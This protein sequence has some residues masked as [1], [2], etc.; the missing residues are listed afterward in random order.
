MQAFEYKVVPAPKRGLKGKGIKG[1]EAR[2]ANALQIMMNELGAEGWEYQRADTLP[3]EER[4]GLTG[5]TTS[6]QHMLV[7]R[8]P[9]VA[10]DMQAD[11][12]Q[13]AEEAPALIEDKTDEKAEDRVAETLALATP[14]AEMATDDDAPAAG[15]SAS[16]GDEDSPRHAA[17]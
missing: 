10:E 5:R 12:A 15:A 1:S 4:Q 13:D 3:V 2:F 17:E 7:F 14:A 9:L 16:S 11:D 8:R 6:F